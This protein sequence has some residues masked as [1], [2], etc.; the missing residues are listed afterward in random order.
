MKT[1]FLLPFCLAIIAYHVAPV[2][3]GDPWATMGVTCDLETT[4]VQIRNK[5]GCSKSRKYLSILFEDYI[6]WDLYIIISVYHLRFRSAI[7]KLNYFS[8]K[9]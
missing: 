5:E 2:C 4:L 1:S 3:A 9:M 6:I 8:L 7:W